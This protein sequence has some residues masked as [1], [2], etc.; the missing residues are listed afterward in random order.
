MGLFAGR[1]SSERNGTLSTFRKGRLL[2][3]KVANLKGPPALLS[4]RETCEG[5]EDSGSA[6]EGDRRAPDFE[7]A[8]ILLRNVY[9]EIIVSGSILRLRVMVA[10]ANLSCIISFIRPRDS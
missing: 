9:N 5:Q 10:S 3:E 4:L 6:R 2:T 8:I 7:Q 1:E